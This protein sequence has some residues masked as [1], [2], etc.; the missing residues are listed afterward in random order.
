[1]IASTIRNANRQKDSDRWWT[2]ED[3]MPESM[4]QEHSEGDAGEHGLAALREHA[5]RIEA[6]RMRQQ[7][8]NHS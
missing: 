6:Y 2:P 7:R 1:M 5:A 8:G 4:K 3:Y